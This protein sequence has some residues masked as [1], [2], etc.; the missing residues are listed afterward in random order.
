VVFCG[1]GLFLQQMRNL[2]TDPGWAVVNIHYK[3]ALASLFTLHK[4]SRKIDRFVLTKWWKLP[5]RITYTKVTFMSLVRSMHEQGLKEE[6]LMKKHV[7]IKLIAIALVMT[8][9]CMLFAGCASDE[10]QG[11]KIQGESSAQNNGFDEVATLSIYLMSS[12]VTDDV[13][14]V[15]EAINQYVE[16]KIGVNVDITFINSGSFQDTVSTMVR[17]GDPVDITFLSEV[18]LRSLISQDA[19]TP[20]SDLLAQYGE[21]IEEAVGKE[22]MEAAYIGDEI[23]AIPSLKDMAMSRMLLYNKAIADEVGVTGEL[24]K[25]ESIFDLTPIYEK[26][27]AV[28]PDLDMFGG[29]PSAQTFDSWASDKLA[30]SLGVLINYGQDSEVT[31]YF[32][33]DEYMELCK[34]MRTWY[35]NGWIDKDIATGTDF[36]DARMKAKTAFSGITSYKPG[37][38]ETCIDRIGYELG[39]CILTD[40]LRTT[41]NVMNATLCIPASSGHP[42]KAMQFLQLWY[43]DPVVGNLIINGIEDVHYEVKEDGGI[44]YIGSADET[45]YYNYGMGSTYG[46]QFITSV[47]TGTAPDVWDQTRAWNE[48]ATISKGFG[49]AFNNADYLNE[50]TACT[51]VL[52][53]YRG[54]LETGTIDPQENIPKFI[55]ELKDNGID[56]I[57]AAKQEQL[58]AFLAQ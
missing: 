23:Y 52:T 32:E 7:R 1:S 6:K 46:N 45:K 28:Y 36:W 12:G 38:V 48:Q 42:D 14:L 15:E 4:K 34:L 58:D 47:W 26:V 41:S 21:G 56:R 31:N 55:Q 57:I 37:N 27:A 8:M 54:D 30:D 3:S 13:D 50:I 29:A 43:T 18:N 24:D 35:T 53:K 17:S 16:P 51:N 22:F 44:G 9:L 39:Y 5:K 10:Q 49:F 40:A 33:S 20:L 19:I 25:V 11:N 2:C